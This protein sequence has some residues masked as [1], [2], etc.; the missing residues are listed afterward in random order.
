[1]STPEGV[2][3]WKTH[4]DSVDLKFDLTPGSQSI[5]T[6]ETYRRVKAQQKPPKAE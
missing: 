6:W 4:G 5:E 1:M 3:W 2:A